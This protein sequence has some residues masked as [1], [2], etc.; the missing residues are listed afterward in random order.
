MLLAL[1]VALLAA[2]LPTILLALGQLEGP[3]A[4]MAG[5]IV[6]PLLVAFLAVLVGMEFPL[7]A[8]A[9]FHTPAKT[10]ARLYTADYVGAAL[11][12]LLVSTWL[13]PVLGVVVV[14]LL[15]AGLNL[16]AAVV[17]WIRKA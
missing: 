9:D 8:Q 15:T 11:G 7:A 4:S 10:S 16:L 1:A 3:I 6:I 14:C 5:R 12:A 2:I 13:I 17:L